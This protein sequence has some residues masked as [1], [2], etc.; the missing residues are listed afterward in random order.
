MPWADVWP[1]IAGV[2]LA[3]KSLDG[4]EWDAMI[5]KL[6]SGRLSGYL[7]HAV[8]DDRRVYRPAHEELVEVLLDPDARLLDNGGRDA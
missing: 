8:E 5:G 2:F 4:N 1:A 6:L 7:A 3:P